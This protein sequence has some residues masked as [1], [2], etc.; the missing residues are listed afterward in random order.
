MPDVAV[1]RGALSNNA[2]APCVPRM[3]N[4]ILNLYVTLISVINIVVIVAHNNQ[5][6]IDNVTASLPHI[7]VKLIDIQWIEWPGPRY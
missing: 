1:A 7:F 4:K 5:D 3:C 2:G 6:L